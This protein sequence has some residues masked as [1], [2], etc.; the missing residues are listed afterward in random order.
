MKTVFSFLFFISGFI[1]YA[2]QP[3][4]Y[5]HDF[6]TILARTKDNNDSLY[7]YNLLPRYYANDS[8]LSRYAMLALLIGF[9]DKPAYQPHKDIGAEQAIFKLNEEKKYD[10]ALKASY[11][12]LQTHPFS[13]QAL[14]EREYTFNQL[15]QPDSANYY[16]A[17]LSKITA[18]MLYTGNGKTAET[19]RFALGLLDGQHLLK[20]ANIPIASYNSGY[21][22]NG[23]FL[24]VLEAKLDFGATIPY[25]FIVQHAKAKMFEGYSKKEIKKLQ[26]EFDKKKK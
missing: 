21:D 20:N 11:T 2:Q 7:Y 22:K 13:M 18:A 17:L 1:T 10:E 9:T 16:A 15:Q 25:Y 6:Q 5:T 4:N 23:N 8:G 12:F 19:A 14:K 26:E 24:D 3:F